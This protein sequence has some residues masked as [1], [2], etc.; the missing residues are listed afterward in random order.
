[1][2]HKE[3]IQ[4]QRL[5]VMG[6]R[7]DKN[8]MRRLNQMEADDRIGAFGKGRKLARAL[9]PQVLPSKQEKEK[10]EAK[11]QLDQNKFT[12]YMSQRGQKFGPQG[13]TGPMNNKLKIQETAVIQ[14][15]TFG[16]KP[17]QP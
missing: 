10:R 4:S 17:S 11:K 14:K 3:Y 1:M 16:V 5:N 15:S 13:Y 6:D 2:R 8:M 9:A 7:V 12:S